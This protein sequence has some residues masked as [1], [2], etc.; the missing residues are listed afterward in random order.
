MTKKT[1]FDKIISSLDS[2]A[3][4]YKLIMSRIG[5]IDNHLMLIENAYKD[6]VDRIKDIESRAYW[7]AEASMTYKAIENALKNGK[8]YDDSPPPDQI[9]AELYEEKKDGE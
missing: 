4:D 9:T 5:A 6:L 2:I 1:K 3:C 7:Q 8:E